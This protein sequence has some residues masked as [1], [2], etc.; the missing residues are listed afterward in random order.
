MQTTVTLAVAE[1]ALGF[2]HRD[3]HWGNLLIKRTT[4]S[5]IK[6]CSRSDL[7]HPCLGVHWTLMRSLQG[8]PIGLVTTSMS[9]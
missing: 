2:E 6:A 9:M 7:F 5:C 3:L 8:L 4:E 1:E